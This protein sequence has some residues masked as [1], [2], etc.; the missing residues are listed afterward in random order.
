MKFI[1]PKNY[2][3]KNRIFG[4]IDYPTAIVN[5]VWD[6]FIYFLLRNIDANIS[7]RIFIFTL[8]SFP[9]LLITIV[10]FN[11]ESPVYTLKYVVRFLIKQ[12]IYLFKKEF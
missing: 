1:I 9:V 6:V 2:K 5:I 11:N 8:L 10:G 12:K 7:I 4:I 3:F